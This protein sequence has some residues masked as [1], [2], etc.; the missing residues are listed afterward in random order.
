MLGSV[1]ELGPAKWRAVWV[2]GDGAEWTKEFTAERDAMGFLVERVPGGL[3]FHDLRHS[4]AR[5]LVSDDG[6]PVNVVQRVMG[7][8]APPTTLNL[9]THAPSGFEGRVGEG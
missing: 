7:H 4:Y 8:E 5:W 9:Y 3:R 6:L 1:V 2:D